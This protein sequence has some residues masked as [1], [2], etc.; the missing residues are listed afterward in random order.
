MKLWCHSLQVRSP[1]SRF[2]WYLSLTEQPEGLTLLHG[3]LV[4]GSFQKQYSICHLGLLLNCIGVWLDPEPIN[5]HI[6]M[7]SILD[8]THL[9]SPILQNISNVVFQLTCLHFVDLRSKCS[10]Y[11]EFPHV[12]NK[13]EKTNICNYPR[14]P[15]DVSDCWILVI[16]LVKKKLKGYIFSSA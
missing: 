7:L 16:I 13:T 4:S 11:L 10:F 2:N 9:P 14:P 15:L 3:A 12:A 8:L 5:A 6:G 1:I